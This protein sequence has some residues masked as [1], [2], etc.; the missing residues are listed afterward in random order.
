[1]E[2]THKK[3]QTNRKTKTARI[4]WGKKKETR[5]TQKIHNENKSKKIRKTE[6]SIE[7]K[8]ELEKPVKTQIT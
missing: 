2:K 5:N 8:R 7:K 1:M 3:I 6:D 4:T